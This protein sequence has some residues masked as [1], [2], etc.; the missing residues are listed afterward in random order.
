MFPREVLMFHSIFNLLQEKGALM[1]LYDNLILVRKAVTERERVAHKKFEKDEIIFADLTT[2][3]NQVNTHS[4]PSISGCEDVKK[5]HSQ[6]LSI[7]YPE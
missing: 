3:I 5:F 6:F 1:K 2:E 7:F 4:P